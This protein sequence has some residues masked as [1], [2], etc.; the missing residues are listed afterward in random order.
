M[1]ESVKE[2]LVHGSSIMDMR[3]EKC[4]Q[5]LLQKLMVGGHLGCVEDSVSK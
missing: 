3:D 2:D 4:T 5:L 1:H